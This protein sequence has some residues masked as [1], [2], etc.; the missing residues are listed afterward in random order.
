MSRP[1]EATIN[2]YLRY[3]ED[4]SSLRD[5]A[6]IDAARAE[7]ERATS[8]IEKLIALSK[9]D[10]L[11]HVDPSELI[12]QFVVAAT[13]FSSANN[14]TRN[15]WRTMGVPVDVLERIGGP[16]APRGTS[17]RSARVTA[18][19][20]EATIPDAGTF[21]LSDLSGSPA[22]RKAVVERLIESGTVEYVGRDEQHE[23]RG[24]RPKV[25]R[26]LA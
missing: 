12:E 5:D 25:Y 16:A 24:A 7:V 11:E 13:A 2:T 20:V 26:R 4:E 3:L 17:T 9:V 14:I 6:A 23:G 15:A 8:P 18:D 10:R 19:D 1:D 22:T 21:R